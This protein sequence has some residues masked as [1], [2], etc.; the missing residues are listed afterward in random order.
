MSAEEITAAFAKASEALAPCVGRPLDNYI[1]IMVETL[2][3][4]L[5]P[6]PFD[7][8]H[9]NVDSLLALVTTD[10]EYQDAFGRA[11]IVP[12][13]VGIYDVTI[14]RN[15]N[16]RQRAELKAIHNA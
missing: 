12:A 4:V 16:G 6:I 1:Q 11:F 15:A 5:V 13:Q 8:T 3:R 2:S 9:G 14:P 10:Q 7:I